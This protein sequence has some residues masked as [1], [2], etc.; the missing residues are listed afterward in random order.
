M[1]NV[2]QLHKDKAIKGVHWVPTG[3]FASW[4][5]WNLYYYSQL[6]QWV[7][8][9]GGMFLVTMNTLWFCQMLYYTKYH[10]ITGLSDTK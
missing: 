1:I 3:Y 4:G 6:D 8:V 7:S 2:I 9:L 5:L 10:I